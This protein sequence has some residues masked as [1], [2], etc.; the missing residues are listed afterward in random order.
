[1]SHL[2]TSQKLMIS[3]M[4]KYEF[5][6][7]VPKDNSFYHVTC[8]II[9]QGSVFD[10]HDYDHGFF[11]HSNGENYYVTCKLFSHS[12]IV[13]LLNS[14]IYEMDL[15]VRQKESLS[16]DQ[17]FNLEQDLKQLLPFQFTRSRIP[18]SNTRTDSNGNTNS[19]HG[20]NNDITKQMVS[21]TD[22]QTDLDHQNGVGGYNVAHPRQ[23]HFPE[24]EMKPNYGRYT[25]A[26]NGN[27]MNNEMSTQAVLMTNI[28]NDN[29]LSRQDVYGMGYAYPQQQYHQLFS[30]E[31]FHPTFNNLMSQPNLKQASTSTSHMNA[32]Y[33]TS[34]QNVFQPQ[35]FLNNIVDQQKQ[36]QV[37]NFSHHIPERETMPD[38][39]GDKNSFNENIGNNIMTIQIVS[40]IN[41]NHNDNN[42][43]RNV[44]GGV[45]GVD[46]VIHLQQH[47]NFYQ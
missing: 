39:N 29:N 10:D 27:T 38:Y 36:T 23:H 34:A 11:Y 41:Q 24:R 43:S 20:R 46:Q 28:N 8:N 1:M 30:S 31:N 44:Q 13:N 37:D 22:G 26:F 47:Q 2:E 42:L 40:D 4:N 35:P 21:N 32:T 16:L 15:D 45:N 33:L 18:K 12:L 5:F 6:H 3:T 25:T 7:Y 14:K 19:L 9:I 17:K